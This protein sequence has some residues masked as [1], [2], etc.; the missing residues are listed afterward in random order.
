MCVVKGYLNMVP[1]AGDQQARLGHTHVEL[2]K[3][4]CNELQVL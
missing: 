1:Q 4:N 3:L 2:C